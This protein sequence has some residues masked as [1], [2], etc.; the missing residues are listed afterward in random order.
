MKALYVILGLSIVLISG[1][2][3]EDNTKESVD[4][5]GGVIKKKD[6]Q[7]YYV[8]RWSEIPFNKALGVYENASKRQ[9]FSK[10]ILVST[11]IPHVNEQ[12]GILNVFD[13][14][15]SLAYW[16]QLIGSVEK[17]DAW[18]GKIT[19]HYVVNSS[20]VLCGPYGRNQWGNHWVHGYEIVTAQELRIPNSNT[21][22][23]LMFY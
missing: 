16:A 14:Y 13:N 17:P 2:S 19:T 15:R 11:N 3:V 4:L 5:G 23:G 18:S 7:M 10:E 20:R 21:N 12:V 22:K 6:G 1:C 9:Y 8:H